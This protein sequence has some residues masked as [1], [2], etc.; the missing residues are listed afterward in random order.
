MWLARIGDAPAGG[1]RY[2]FECKVCGAQTLVS[3][4]HEESGRIEDGL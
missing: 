1:R 4:A 2:V 3:A